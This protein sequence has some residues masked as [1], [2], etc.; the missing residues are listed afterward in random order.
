[1]KLAVPLLAC[2]GVAVVA[3][4]T[5]LIGTR[6]V[7]PVAVK[8][9]ANNIVVI[10]SASGMATSKPGPLASGTP[11]PSPSPISSPPPADVLNVDTLAGEMLDVWPDMRNRHDDLNKEVRDPAW[12]ASS[13]ALLREQFAAMPGLGQQGRV[14][15]IRCGSETCQIVGEIPP[16]TAAE[17]MAAMQ[18]L[19]FHEAMDSR[20]YGEGTVAFG[21]SQVNGHGGF[22]YYFTRARES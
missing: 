3:A 2:G 7:P 15:D 11:I 17:A 22:I 20:G 18:D 21:P 14:L 9:P 5:F 16:S 19:S 1:M 10:A 6:D 4:A 13:E 12:A 8:G